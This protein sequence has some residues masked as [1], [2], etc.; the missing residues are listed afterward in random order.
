MSMIWTE[1]LSTGV[2]W[3]DAEHRLLFIRINNLMLSMKQDKGKEE[4][5]T[6]FSFLTL[7]VSEHFRREEAAMENTR[8]EMASNHKAQHERFLNNIYYLNEAFKRDG[9]RGHLIEV[10]RLLADWFA[11]HVA[12]I[13]KNLGSFLLTFDKRI[14]RTVVAYAGFQPHHR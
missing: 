9:S 4:L 10:R 6:L 2:A 5:S 11:E 8:Y 14:R 7:Y 13:D 3:Q 1:G 12:K